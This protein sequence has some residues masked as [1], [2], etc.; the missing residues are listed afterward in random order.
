LLDEILD[1]VRDGS[2]DWIIR[3]GPDGKTYRELNHQKLKQRKIKIGALMWLVTK[4]S[5]KKCRVRKDR[6]NE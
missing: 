3:T 6:A 5:A 2:N 1:T 4:L